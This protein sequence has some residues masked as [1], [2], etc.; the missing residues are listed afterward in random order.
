MERG[1]VSKLFIAEVFL[2]DIGKGVEGV[3][4]GR[5]GVKYSAIF[6]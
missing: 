2:V 3:V 6:R 4:K 5:E 1:F